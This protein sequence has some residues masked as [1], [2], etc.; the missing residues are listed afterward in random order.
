MIIGRM[1]GGP[2]QVDTLGEF[3]DMYEF[4]KDGEELPF[5]VITFVGSPKS[6][7]FEGLGVSRVAV[8]Y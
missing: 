1:K 7:V 4:S 6:D 5:G 2:P 3:A 8:P